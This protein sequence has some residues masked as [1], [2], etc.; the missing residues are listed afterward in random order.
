MFKAITKKNQTNDAASKP[1]TLTALWS[2]KQAAKEGEGSSEQ[3]P[4]P[5]EPP[6]APS[7]AQEAA[8]DAPPAA[9]PRAADGG[10]APQV[11]TGG[12]VAIGAAPEPS[13]EPAVAAAQ[14][15]AAVPA[16]EQ[17]PEAKPGKVG[18]G[19]RARA[20]RWPL[21]CLRLLPTVALRRPHSL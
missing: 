14:A 16:A 4:A 5:D 15:A 8:A 18:P 12:D 11:A 1:G 9:A 13:P 7:D 2:K 19:W 17:A 21:L 10:A 20:G 3:T 6:A